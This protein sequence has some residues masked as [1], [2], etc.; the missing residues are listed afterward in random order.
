MR[1]GTRDTR[2]RKKVTDEETERR[3]KETETDRDEQNMRNE[4]RTK[5]ETCGI[6][7]IPAWDHG[8]RKEQERFYGQ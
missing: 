6:R 8:G 2:E 1:D 4:L 3:E 7:N 5:I